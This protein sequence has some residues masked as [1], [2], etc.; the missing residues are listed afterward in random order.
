MDLADEAARRELFARVGNSSRRTLVVTEGL[1]IYL[2]SEAVAGLARDLHA[3]PTF[4]LWLIDLAS[5]DLLRM[6]EKNLGSGR[7]GGRG[8]VP[9]RPGREHA[10]LRADGVA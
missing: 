9:V 6:M 5:P 7:P 4:A 2:P 1:L 8:A 3:Q 10:V